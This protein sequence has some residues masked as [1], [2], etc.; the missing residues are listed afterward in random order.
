M[1]KII[2]LAVVAALLLL[3]FASATGSKVY[4]PIQAKQFQTKTV[5]YSHDF[6][7]A[8]TYLGTI[9]LEGDVSWNGIFV[10]CKNFTLSGDFTASP[11]LTYENH[12][13]SCDPKGEGHTWR[14][15]Q[16]A[17]ADLY[18]LGKFIERH[19][20]ECFTYYYGDTICTAYIDA[21]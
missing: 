10:W 18:Y 7:N 13:V 8:T 16:H 21:K 12:L 15:T 14:V 11:G 9:S 20:I 19:V 6:Y 5:R 17:S 1:K 2:L 4:L 3:A